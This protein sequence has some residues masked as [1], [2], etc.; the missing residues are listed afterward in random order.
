MTRHQ[1]LAPSH[2]FAHFMVFAL[3]GCSMG[4]SVSGSFDRSLDVSGPIRLELNNVSGDVTIVG[5]AGQ[6]SPRARR[7]PCLGIRDGQ[8]RRNAWTTSLPGPPSN[9]RVPLS[10]S[11]KKPRACATSLLPIRSKCPAKQK[12]ARRVFL[13]HNPFAT[14]AAQC[15]LTQSLGRFTR[16]TSAGKLSC[17]RSVDPSSQR[18]CGDDVRATSVSGKT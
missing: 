9:S 10:G 1:K 16:R 3:V 8:S 14:C 7:C 4:P 6:Q 13:D 5:S 18:N 15:R 2:G 11:E 17:L 12:S